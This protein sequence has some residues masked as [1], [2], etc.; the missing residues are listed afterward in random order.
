MQVGVTAAAG[1]N[2]RQA[3]GWTARFLRVFLLVPAV[4]VSAFAV[5]T[6]LCLLVESGTLPGAA[7][8][9]ATLSSAVSSSAASPALQTVAGGMAT[10]TSITFS[11][12]VIAV[13]QSAASLSPVVFEQFLRRRGNQVIFGYFV[14]LTMAAFVLL[15][16]VPRGVKPLFGALVTGV[17]TVVAVGL[18]I[19]LVYVTVE[20]M[21]PLNVIA[22]LHDCTLQARHAESS[23]L[24]GSRRTERSCHPVRARCHSESSGYVTG[25]DVTALRALLA[26]AGRA[27]ICLRVSIGDSVALGQALAIIRDD[28]DAHAADL[29]RQVAAAVR[30]GRTRD[31]ST[32]ATSG[33]DALANIG[34]SAA[35]SA[36]HNPEVARQALHALH[37][38]A[39]RLMGD[40][41]AIDEA[42]SDRCSLVYPDNDL[43]R[44]L[45]GIG[46]MALAA[47]ESYEDLTA[48][49]TIEVL[50]ALAGQADGWRRDLLE[51]HLRDALDMASSMPSTRA[52]RRALGGTAVATA[53]APTSSPTGG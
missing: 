41:Q 1:G 43:E 36:R 17:L 52:L 21:R 10:L 42:A 11:L 50:R 26:D 13:Q 33:I 48:S 40:D 31:L 3:A 34:W 6:A 24:S 27:E 37:D 30:I 8:V 32:D 44:V 15:T 39:V 49:R 7:G 45:S 22:A 28:N 19:A 47:R 35:S 12:L 4:V 29:A 14:G 20:Q 16:V 51:E 18:L 38:L 9:D 25:I 2:V 5:V 46:G 23:L 53:P